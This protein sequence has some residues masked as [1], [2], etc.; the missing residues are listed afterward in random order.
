[1]VY[2]A[3]QTLLYSTIQS[4][5]PFNNIKTITRGEESTT[6][7]YNSLGMPTLIQKGDIKLFQEYDDCGRCIAI[8]AGEGRVTR[9]S[10]DSQGRLLEK[11]LPDGSLLGYKY[12]SDSHLIEFHLPNDVIWKC[13]YDIMGR[14]LNEAIHK[15]GKTSQNVDYTY[16]NGYLI[17]KNDSMNRLHVYDCDNYGRL[18]QENVENWQRTYSYDSRGY[19]TSIEESKKSNNCI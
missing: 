7:N 19:L 8:I 2:D 18:I 9:K 5:D 14:K 11:L 4:N 13:N 15:E 3:S 16:H 12:D 6:T 17:H 10:Y 1:M